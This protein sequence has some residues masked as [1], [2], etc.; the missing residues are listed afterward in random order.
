MAR[1]PEFR[2]PVQQGSTP[3][4]AQRDFTVKVDVGDLRPNS[5]YYYRFRAFNAV[6]PVGRTRTSAAGDVDS[7]R[8]A[9][10]SCS[11]YEWGYFNAY[12]HISR[13]QD[14]MAVIHLG[15]YIYEYGTGVYGDTTIGRIHNPPH[16]LLS[17]D[18][19]RSRYAQ[20]RSDPDLQEV[21][22][23]HPF[24]TTWDDHEIANNAYAEGAENHQPEE[25]SYTKRRDIAKKVY[26]EWMPVRDGEQL[27]RKF[28]FGRMA[29]LIMLD[30]RLAGRSAPVKNPGDSSYHN[31]E[32]TILG[33]EQY[34]WLTDALVRSR[35]KWKIIGNQVIFSRLN[36]AQGNMSLNMDAWDGYPAEQKRLGRLLTINQFDN[37]IF[38]TG[39][40]H[41]SWAFETRIDSTSGQRPLAVELGT[42]SVNSA[43]SNESYAD[44][45]VIA[46]EDLLLEANPHLKYVNLRDHGYLLLTLKQDY[47]R[48][49]FY[50]VPTN[51][52]RSGYAFLAKQLWI[53]ERNY[54]LLESRPQE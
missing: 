15:D 24:I 44:S 1:D 42:T 18:D 20:Y 41:A 6:S 49:D 54:K 52:E 14:L 29:R 26:Y 4:S 21:H 13:Q 27:Y 25:G 36:L 32:R 17:L 8:F 3:T 45:L 10:V 9:V 51:R 39:D 37:L 28:D 16:E 48:A 23:L 5:T 22:R 7:L 46:H 2:I 34:K 47:A 35:A 33:N 50:Y 43:N 53:R 19:Y 30:E 40:T 31:E 38:V 12:R 11:N